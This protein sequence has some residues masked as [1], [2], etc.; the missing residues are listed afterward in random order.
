[1]LCMSLSGDKFVLFPDTEMPLQMEISFIHVNF[2]YKRENVYA[3][4]KELGG[5]K[6]LFLPLL[7][8]NCL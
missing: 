3:I 7:F 2:L 1:M 4:L 6:E 5:G 8:L